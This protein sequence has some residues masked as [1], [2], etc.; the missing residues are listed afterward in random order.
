M[1]FFVCFKNLYI[2]FYLLLI[3]SVIS[4]KYKNLARHS[5]MLAR[6]TSLKRIA[7]L[8]RHFPSFSPLLQ[9]V[10]E[11]STD[12]KIIEKNDSKSGKKEFDNKYSYTLNLPSTAF[13]QRA[14][15]IVREP[16]LQKVSKVFSLFYITLY[17]YIFFKLLIFFFCIRIKSEQFIILN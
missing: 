5:A 7:K 11:A 8:N 16:E 17:I 15:S 9:Q 3:S 6:V 12:K 4:F 2:P 1:H 10:R 13:D 14:N